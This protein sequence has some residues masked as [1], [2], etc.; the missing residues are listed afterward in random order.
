MADYSAK[1]SLEFTS[2][3][4]KISKNV[5]K[6]TTKI[7]KS[8]KKIGSA[9]KKTASK[10]KGF[11]SKIKGLVS[12]AGLAKAGIAAITA[13]AAAGAAAFIAFTK[14]TVDWAD[15]VDKGAGKIGVSTDFY[16]KFIKVAE[17]AGLTV[18]DAEKTMSKFN[19]SID[20]AAQG[21][22]EGTRIFKKLGI[23]V[24]DTNGDIKNQAI[25][26]QEAAVAFDK[27]EDGP[28][29]AADAMELFGAKGKILN[30]FK[31]GPEAFRKAMEAQMNILSQRTVKAGA[32]FND[33]ITNF[34][35]S[36]GGLGNSL[37]PMIEKMTAFL[38]ALSKSDTISRS[39][40]GVLISIS[41]LVEDL[42]PSVE[43]VNNKASG[44]NMT[45][46]WIAAVI[47]GIGAAIDLWNVVGPLM[48]A[49]SMFNIFKNIFGLVKKLGAALF[50]VLPDS[51]KNFFKDVLDDFLKF[52]KPVTDFFNSVAGKALMAVF[53]IESATVAG[54]SAGMTLEQV[55]ERNEKIKNETPEEKA[56]RK[57]DEFENARKSLEFAKQKA[58]EANANT[59][60]PVVVVK[61]EN[62]DETNA[63]LRE[64]NEI[65]KGKNTNITVNTPR[66]ATISN[67][68]LYYGN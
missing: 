51:W 4:D 50:N 8:F 10:I 29:K 62:T 1:L 16:Q 32:A 9:V 37:T 44:L 47:D 33:A 41:G 64:G 6:A 60:T 28:I 35:N 55:K 43:D 39:L 46:S 48:E 14:S 30:A 68:N 13:A 63:I 38:T 17:L 36:F 53:G 25:L 15:T 49:M 65:A 20:D 23:S 67:Q 42:T 22:G 24:R 26:M 54:S 11:A 45:L 58:K 56:V 12:S 34:K 59:A 19:S 31:E 2:N 18:K 61:N 40:E 7:S 21:I 27:L 52:I 5:A 3:L 57:K 66:Q